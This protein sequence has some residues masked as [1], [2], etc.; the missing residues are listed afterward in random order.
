M[1]DQLPHEEEGVR[2]VQ[3]GV[4]MLQ[5][6]TRRLYTFEKRILKRNPELYKAPC[7]IF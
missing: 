7:G 6:T 4:R 1:V 2:C 5:S 3:S